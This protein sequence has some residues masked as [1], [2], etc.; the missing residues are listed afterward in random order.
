MNPRRPAFGREPD[1][2]PARHPGLRAEPGADA[3]RRGRAL[4]GGVLHA[5]A[6]PPRRAARPLGHPGHRLLALGPLARHHRGPGHL[7]DRQRAARRAARQGDPRLLGL[8]LLLRLRDLRGRHRHLLGP[9]ARAGV[10]LQDPARG[11]RRGCRPNSAPTRRASAGS[12]S[13]PSSTAPASTPPTSCAPSR[14]GRCATRCRRCRGWPRSPRSAAS[15]S[16]TRS[17][18]TRTASPPTASR[19]TWSST[20]CAPPTTRSAGG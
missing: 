19:W 8:R 14:T 7:P 16:S 10:S 4:R 13:T 2:D 1:A 11:C 5:Q 12:T 17:P 9:L 15:R 6:D 18:S 20:P 3:P